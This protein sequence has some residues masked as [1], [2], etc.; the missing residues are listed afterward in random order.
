MGDAAVPCRSL[1]AAKRWLKRVLRGRDGRGEY[2]QV[3][4]DGDGNG[5]VQMT[6]LEGTGANGSAGSNGGPLD[7][8]EEAQALVASVDSTQVQPASLSL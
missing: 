1:G 8:D 4:A 7:W 6:D 2:A 5:A 3:G